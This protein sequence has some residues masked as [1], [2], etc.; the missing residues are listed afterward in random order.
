[1]KKLKQCL[2]EMYVD[3][4]KV[5][6]KYNIKVMLGGGSAL[7]AVRHGGFIPWDD[8]LDLLMS[9]EDYDKFIS[10]FDNEL[11]DLYEITSP[12]S[13]YNVSN[14]FTKVY[15][16]NTELVEIFN[17]NADT[18]KGVYVDIF[19]IEYIPENMIIRFAKG[20][21]ANV[22]YY[23]GN[24]VLIYQLRN[25]ILKAFFSAS[26]KGKINYKLRTSIGFFGSFISYKKWFNFYDNYLARGKIS[27]L[28]GIPSGRG[29][30]FGEILP[31]DV[32]FPPKEVTFEGL[33]AY[34]PNNVDL[35]LRNLYGDYMEIPPIEKRERHYYI[36]FNV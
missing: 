4:F 30:Y 5:C 19:P 32:F 35:Y 23:I 26:I 28:C 33:K 7:G 8:D 29:H 11:S 16:K 1:M 24:S 2:L 34:V 31:K 36:K 12:N 22:I 18:P 25:D 10:V 20:F 21:V 14:I 3:I 27:S 13:K 6:E 15:K 17:L 9:R